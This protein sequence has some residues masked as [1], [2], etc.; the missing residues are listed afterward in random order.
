MH[1]DFG[2][3]KSNSE[4]VSIHNYSTLFVLMGILHKC[5][6]TRFFNSWILIKTTVLVKF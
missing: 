5:V 3:T 4:E 2:R 6:D 1:A